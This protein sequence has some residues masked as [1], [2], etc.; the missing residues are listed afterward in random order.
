MKL[1]CPVKRHGGSHIEL[2]GTK[3]HFEE[4]PDGNHVAD[5]KD[6]AHQDRLLSIGYTIYRPGQAQ[7][8]E[9]APA[10]KT[11]EDASL[12]GSSVHQESFEIGGRTVTLGEVVTAAFARSELSIED[13][14]A[15]A[16]PDRHAMLDEELDIMAAD[17][18]PKGD[19][20]AGAPPAVDPAIAEREELV[21]QYETKFGTKPHPRLG[22]AKLREALEA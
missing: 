5:V 6:P 20:G 12:L 16:E 11:L 21:K 13:W 9:A 10:K 8:V 19:A 17:A 15:L 1:V 4:Q 2:W 22:I 18:E 7:P 14:N 3:Y